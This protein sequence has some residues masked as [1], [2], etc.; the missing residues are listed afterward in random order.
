MDSTLLSENK[1]HWALFND[2][3]IDKLFYTRAP[4]TINGEGLAFGLS[5][6]F[7]FCSV[8]VF[9]FTGVQYFYK[10]QK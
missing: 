8:C 4:H 5:V 7:L 9:Q 2:S 6:L 1:R 3:K 10:T